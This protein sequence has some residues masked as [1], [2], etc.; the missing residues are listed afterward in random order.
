MHRSQEITN[1]DR[2]SLQQDRMPDIWQYISGP[3][4]QPYNDSR[5]HP[6]RTP[7]GWV[8]TSLSED[9]ADLCVQWPLCWTIWQREVKKRDLYESSSM[10][11]PSRARLAEQVTGALTKVGIDSSHY[12]S[13]SLGSGAAIT[14]EKQGIGDTT[15]KTLGRWKSSTCQLYI[16][17]STDGSS[18][19]TSGSRQ[20]KPI[21]ERT[22]LTLVSVYCLFFL[23]FCIICMEG[24]RYTY[25]AGGSGNVDT[26]WFGEE[27]LHPKV[28]VSADLVISTIILRKLKG[29]APALTAT[30]TMNTPC[31]WGEVNIEVIS[32]CSS[33]SHYPPTSAT[34][35]Y[36]RYHVASSISPI[37][38]EVFPPGQPTVDNAGPLLPALDTNTTLCLSHSSIN[39]SS[40]ALQIL[41]N[42]NKTQHVI[43]VVGTIV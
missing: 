31:A 30:P 5:T 34:T 25:Q 35:Y 17:M 11:S 28:Q 32:W 19:S 40:T 41:K 12:S 4:E 18:V 21:Q 1:T 33:S 10:I 14:A 7:S 9:P 38:E 23:I 29:A 22:S 43:N 13:H 27:Q 16:K 24:P 42:H 15:I 36:R 20:G 8:W 2:S 26:V 39:C 3:Y 6:K 37:M